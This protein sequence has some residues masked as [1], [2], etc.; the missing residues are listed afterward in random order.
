MLEDAVHSPAILHEITE[1]R[2]GKTTDYSINEISIAHFLGAQ[3]CTGWY[4]GI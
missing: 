4:K 2:E 1:T 3:F